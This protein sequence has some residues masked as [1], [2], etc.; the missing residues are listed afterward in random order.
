MSINT[1]SDSDNES[2]H[3]KTY[4]Q[5]G[6]SHLVMHDAIISLDQIPWHQI[7]QEQRDKAYDQAGPS[8]PRDARPARANKIEQ[9]VAQLSESYGKNEKW[10]NVGR[11]YVALPRNGWENTDIR[12]DIANAKMSEDECAYAIKILKNTVKDSKKKRESIRRS[13]KNN[14]TDKKR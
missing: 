5:A 4:H 9:L 2:S 7:T 11:N 3:E 14:Y 10:R 12:Y 13:L 8:R 1:L 6:T